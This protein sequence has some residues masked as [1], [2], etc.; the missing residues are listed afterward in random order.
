MGRS[1]QVCVVGAGFSEPERPARAGLH[2]HATVAIDH[3]LRDAGLTRSDIDGL[4]TYPHASF[5]GAGTR[6]G[7]DV[8]S[9]DYV[10]RNLGFAEITWAAE[11]N[12]GMI[13]TSVVQAA[14][15]LSAGLCSN[16]L[17]W[18]AMALPERRYGHLDTPPAATG[19]D[20]FTVPW[21]VISPVQ[22]HALAYRKYLVR[23]KADPEMLGALAVESRKRA[24]DNPHAFFRNRPLTTREYSASRVISDPLRLLDCDV[25]V[26]GC[27]ALVLT[28]VDKARHA[29]WSARLAGAAMNIPTNPMPLHYTIDDYQERGHRVAARLWRSAGLKAS[30][31]D[32]AQIYDGFA[33]SVLYWLESAGFCEPGEALHFL[34]DGGIAP[35]GTLPLNTFG[36]S[37]SAGRLH[38]LAHLAEAAQQV[39]GRAGPRQLPGVAAV[40]AFVGSPML[41][42]G[43]F[44]LTRND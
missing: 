14:A 9:V 30:D 13:S 34:Q 41:D 12:H 15:A 42:G 3:A 6:D 18:R 20:Q 7:V 16:A 26:Q 8:V 4:A 27:V 5:V 33:P 1:R 38:G 31:L 25:P 36:G 39:G 17:V 22:W 43:A 11:A 2:T 24:R 37:L 19:G 23:Y 40:A 35:G 21:N 10:A 28:T 44:V 32:A 29:P